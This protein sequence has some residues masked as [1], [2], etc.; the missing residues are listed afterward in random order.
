MTPIQLAAAADAVIDGCLEL[1]HLAHKA[2][3]DSQSFE[4]G[5]KFIQAAQSLA[6]RWQENPDHVNQACKK[7]EAARRILGVV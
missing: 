2:E 4:V 5:V 3:C 6:A 7:L 1:E